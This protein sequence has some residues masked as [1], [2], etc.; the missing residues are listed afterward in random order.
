MKSRETLIRMRRFEAEEKQR[1]V[2]DLEGMIGEFKRMAADLDLQIQA[3]QDRAGVNDVTHYAYPTFAK[4]A[5]QRRDNLMASVADLEVKLDAARDELIEAF[6]E[7]KKVELVEE[8]DASRERATR[9][10]REQAELDEFARQA[11]LSMAVRG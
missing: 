3:E 6:E 8:R 9:G 11:R 2:A 4:A 5:I 1:T 10:A 7:L